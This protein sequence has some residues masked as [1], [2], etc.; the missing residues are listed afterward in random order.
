MAMVDDLTIGLTQLMAVSLLLADEGLAGHTCR[1][2]KGRTGLK[3]G[4][5]F[6]RRIWF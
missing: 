6:L 2:Q 5:P 4:R 3:P 1:T